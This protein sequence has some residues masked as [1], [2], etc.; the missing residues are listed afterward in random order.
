VATVFA[1]LLL[2]PSSAWSASAPYKILGIQAKLFYETL[3]TFSNDVLSNPNFAL[4]NV[5]IGEGDAA[6]PSNSTLVLVQVSGKG[7]SYEPG[8]KVNLVA[9]E[10]KKITLNRSREIGILPTTGKTLVAY[11]IYDTGGKAVK[12]TAQLLG[13]TQRS[14]TVRTIKFVSGE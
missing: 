2:S 10:G 11:W 6:A 5:F 9:A 7:G 12:L 13:Q 8:R 1:G 3:G 14:T 4:F